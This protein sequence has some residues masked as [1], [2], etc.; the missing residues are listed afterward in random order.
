MG[1][2][3]DTDLHRFF[4]RGEA[5]L[6]LSPFARWEKG[7]HRGMR[8]GERIANEELRVGGGGGFGAVVK[9]TQ[10]GADGGRWTQI[11][12]PID[13]DFCVGARRALPYPPVPSVALCVSQGGATLRPY[14]PK[15]AAKGE[16]PVP[17]E[18][19][20]ANGR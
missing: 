14:R 1:P 4:C 19:P 6:A 2:P 7:E 3:I 20:R 11:K 13:A 8:A 16:R 18:P 17:L 12:P 10:M 9:G 5:C 15:G